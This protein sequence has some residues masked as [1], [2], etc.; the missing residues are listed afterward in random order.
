MKKLFR[1]VRVAACL[2][3]VACAGLE[4]NE[5]A[6]EELGVVEEEVGSCPTTVSC[7][8]SIVGYPYFMYSSNNCSGTI[9]CVYRNASYQIRATTVSAPAGCTSCCAPAYCPNP[10]CGQLTYSAGWS[11]TAP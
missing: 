3:L 5:L 8:G 1:R 2:V 6:P 7:P 11:C 10:R 9:S 4:S